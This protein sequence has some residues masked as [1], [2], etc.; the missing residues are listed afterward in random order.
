MTKTNT[1]SWKRTPNQINSRKPKPK[2]KPMLENEVV[3]KGEDK[4]FKGPE[5][6]FKL[7]NH[8]HRVRKGDS[9]QIK[10]PKAK[11][12]QKPILISE[13]VQKKKRK[14]KTRE[15]KPK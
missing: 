11:P 10:T 7:P 8:E 14:A 5:G 12:K 4:H 13:P 6:K 15:C 9:N 2:Q 1:T 3:P